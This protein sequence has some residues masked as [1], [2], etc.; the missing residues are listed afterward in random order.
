MKLR[1]ILWK[2]SHI[3]PKMDSL[4]TFNRDEIT[5][6]IERQARNLLPWL[7]SPLSCESCG[8][9]CE[10]SHTYDPQTAAFNQGACPSWECP[11]CG[12]EYRRVESWHG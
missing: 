3:L 10:A 4:P 12:N 7:E 5:E 1:P 2:Q 9:M 8:A 6:N 11:S